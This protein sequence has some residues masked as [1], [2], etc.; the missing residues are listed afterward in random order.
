L[1]ML[2]ILLCFFLIVALTLSKRSNSYVFFNKQ[3]EDLLKT[4]P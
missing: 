3:I 1:P 2:L 4:S